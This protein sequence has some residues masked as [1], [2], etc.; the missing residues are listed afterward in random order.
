LDALGWHINKVGRGYE[1]WEH[2]DG[3]TWLHVWENGRLTG[4]EDVRQLAKVVAIFD[5][6]QAPT[7]VCQYCGGSGE[8][9]RLGRTPGGH[10]ISEVWPCSN[11]SPSTVQSAAVPPESSSKRYLVYMTTG[12]LMESPG[13]KDEDHHEVE[14]TDEDDAVQKW[15]KLVGLQIDNTHQ[16]E[17]KR[18]HW[19]YWGWKI[20]VTPLVREA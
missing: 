16:L 10:P 11:C 5:P 20:T 14:A 17:K 1:R 4:V 12:G 3:E 18:K 13:W 8:I 15:A 9:R 6:P 2:R 19:Y 7:E